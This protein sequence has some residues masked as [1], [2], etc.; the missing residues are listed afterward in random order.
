MHKIHLLPN[1]EETNGRLLRTLCGLTI[2]KRRK[3]NYQYDPSKVTCCECNPELK[4]KPKGTELKKDK[5]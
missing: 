5:R 3:K 1:T 2:T 4:P